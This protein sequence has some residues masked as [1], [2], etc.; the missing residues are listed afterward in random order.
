MGAAGGGAVA[1]VAL[2]ALAST[3]ASSATCTVA[4]NI[5]CA[6]ERAG[7]AFSCAECAGLH[8]RELQQAGCSNDDIAAWC[9]G[10]APAQRPR[11]PGS[12]L[13]ATASWAATLNKWTGMDPLQEW[14]R[15]YSSFENGSNPSAF[16][17]GC[18]RYA[19][20]LVV[21]RNAINHTFG[22]Y[23]TRTWNKDDCC[24]DPVN[25]CLPVSTHCYVGDASSDFVFG[26]APGTPA[27]FGSR[28]VGAASERFI[29]QLVRIRSAKPDHV[30]VLAR[31]LY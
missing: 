5:A 16:H 12:K 2:A 3:A 15:C 17:L 30:V 31:D 11:F 6:A 8:Q 19:T 13:V 18:D 28:S 22:G 20:T 21:A 29:Y 7:G 25:H 27:R 14:V 10:V 26:L 1:V 23:A 4:L 9:A 24:R